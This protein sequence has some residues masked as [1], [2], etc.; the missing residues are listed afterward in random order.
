MANE[1]VSEG[2]S[3]KNNKTS[4]RSDFLPLSPFFLHKIVNKLLEPQAA[5]PHLGPYWQNRSDF[6]HFSHAVQLVV[7]SN[8]RF[9][10]TL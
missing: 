1:R 4:P 9:R 3:D 10:L 2:Q 5:P 6:L 7:A 8:V